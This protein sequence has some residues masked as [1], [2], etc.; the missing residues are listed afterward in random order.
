MYKYSSKCIDII[1]IIAGIA[2]MVDGYKI[3]DFKEIIY[4]I[5]RGFIVDFN[6]KAYFEIGTFN[7]NRNK[8]LSLDSS[9]KSH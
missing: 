1:A 7:I 2:E 6:L 8:G 5:Y 9:W 4:T 3:T